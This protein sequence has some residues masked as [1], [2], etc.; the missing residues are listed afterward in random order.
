M[1]RR[2]V[3][4]LDT[5]AW[6][7]W[8]ADRAKLPKKLQRRLSSA[9]ELAIS[10]ISCWEVGML[11]ERGRLRLRGDTRMGIRDALSLDK[12]RVIPVTDAIAIEAGLLGPSFHGDPADRLIVATALD[13]CATLVTK[14]ERIRRSKLVV[15]L[16]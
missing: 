4:V 16:W 5:H 11:V 1:G 9:R 7:W 3:I 10:A 6:L 2:E 15:T 14:D 8:A 12:L 13:L